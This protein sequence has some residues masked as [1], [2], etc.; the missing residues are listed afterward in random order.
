MLKFR[1]TILRMEGKENSPTLRNWRLSLE[2]K[3][4]FGLS[5]AFM[6]INSNYRQL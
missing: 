5:T 2:Q 1:L 6:V 3:E 4:S